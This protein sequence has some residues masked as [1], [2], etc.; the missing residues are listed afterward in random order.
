MEPTHACPGC[1]APVQAW[2]LEALP[3]PATAGRA[4]AQAS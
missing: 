3:G 2:D 4:A 1:G